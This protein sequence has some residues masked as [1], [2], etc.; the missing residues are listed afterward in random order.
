MNATT[1]EMQTDF[2]QELQK[3]TIGVRLYQK[4]F[5]Q[6]KSLND[7]QIERAAEE[8][9]AESRAISASKKLFAKHAAISKVKKTLGQAR[10]YWK[11][12]TIDFPEDGIRLMRTQNI[13]AFEEMM[14]K[15]TEELNSALDELDEAYEEIKTLAKKDLGTL[16]C[17]ADYPRSLKDRFAI[18]YDYIQI[19]PSEMLADLH[20]ELYEREK[21][22]MASMFQE[23]VIKAEEDFA[24][25][26]TKLLD[27]AIESLTPSPDGK[28]KRI[29]DATFDNFQ[30]FFERFKTM[31]TGSNPA[32]SEA[33]SNL[34]LATKGIDGNI[35][36]KSGDVK[37]I[38]AERMQEA[39][40]AI[41][42]VIVVRPD[43]KFSL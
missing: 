9:D 22:K 24:K 28:R 1:M 12:V 10:N 3:N 18:G 41:D 37:S 31:D 35:V 11:A 19:R 7:E 15:Y 6:S 16:Y 13:P 5:G 29:C 27:H 25:E 4:R 33:I 14:T 30:A 42:Q 36:R 32:L 26:V 17:E 39:R 40:A 38:I 8:F 20:P 34:Q 21:A 23:A 2:A 43:R